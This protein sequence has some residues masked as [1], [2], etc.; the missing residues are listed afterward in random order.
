[1]KND[2]KLKSVLRSE[3]ALQKVLHPADAQQRSHL[4]KMNYIDVNGLLENLS[5]L[6]GPLDFESTNA[7]NESICFLTEEEI[8]NRLQCSRQSSVLLGNDLHFEYL[9]P[10]AII[11]DQSDG[12][13]NWCIGF[14][15]C[16]V[17]DISFKA[18]HLSV[19]NSDRHDEWIRKSSDDIQIV[20]LMQII[21][22]EVFGK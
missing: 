1:M 11:W 9:K 5:I 21:P 16:K 17:D 3:I 8:Y 6:L 2:R 13:R 4:Y 15:V 22:V 19:K 18:D 7:T 10:L 14:Y 20:N 12:E